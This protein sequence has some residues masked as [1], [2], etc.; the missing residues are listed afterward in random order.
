MKHL[1]R[2]Y[3]NFTIATVHCASR[4]AVDAVPNSALRFFEPCI[5][6]MRAPIYC[7]TFGG[8]AVRTIAVQHTSIGLG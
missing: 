2:L 7:A 5:M 4:N 6:A 8:R 3:T 1:R